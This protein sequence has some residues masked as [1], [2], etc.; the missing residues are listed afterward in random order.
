MEFAREFAYLMTSIT[1]IRWPSGLI[2]SQT[3]TLRMGCRPKSFT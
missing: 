3:V 1:P 2:L